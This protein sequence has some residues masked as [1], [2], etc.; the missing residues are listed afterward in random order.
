MTF[1]IKSRYLG[2][3]ERI[4]MGQKLY[5]KYILFHF[6]YCVYQSTENNLKS[7]LLLQNSYEFYKIMKTHMGG[8]DP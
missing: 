2:W 4:E 3:L 5:F 1:E 8:G 7:V 6:F